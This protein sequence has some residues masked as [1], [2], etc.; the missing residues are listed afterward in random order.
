VNQDIIGSLFLRG[1]FS[2]ENFPDLFWPITVASIVFLIATGVLY[3]V[4]T[5]RLRH[6]PPLLNLQEWLLWTGLA[7][8]GLMVV[9]SIFKFYFVFVLVTLV[10]GLGTMVWIRFW[11]FP[12]L[13][14]SYN[15]VLRHERFLSEQ[16]YHSP[17]ATIRKRSARKQKSK[18]KAKRRR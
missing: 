8:F 9:Y 17:E 1:G 5:K 3:Y 12:P 11:R 6:H 15:K 13:I 10:V 16:K 18:S 7:V 14:A 4:Q 2:P